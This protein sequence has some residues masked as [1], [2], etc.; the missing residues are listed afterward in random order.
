MTGN[1]ELCRYAFE[2]PFLVSSIAT[3]LPPGHYAVASRPGED[4]LVEVEPGTWAAIST[5]ELGA[6]VREDDVRAAAAKASRSAL[7]PAEDLGAE[8]NEAVP[9]RPRGTP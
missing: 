5:D 8:W 7:T 3:T 1:R 4:M 2:Q 6:G 9:T